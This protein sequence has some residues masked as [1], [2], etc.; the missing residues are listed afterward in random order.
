MM[1]GPEGTLRGTLFGLREKMKEAQL[2]DPR[3]F[4]VVQ[5]LKKKAPGEYIA[6]PR[7]TETRKTKIRSINYRLAD[8]G[9]LISHLDV[10]GVPLENSADPGQDLP[11]V[12][13][14]KFEGEKTPRNMS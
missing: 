1:P 8:D 4:Q 6:E 10:V 7:S 3:L 9:L 11:V 5:Q 2:K 12:P 14:V 13:D